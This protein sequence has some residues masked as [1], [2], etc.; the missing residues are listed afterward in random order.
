MTQITD[1]EALS[2]YKGCSFWS[3]FS[4][5]SM[6]WKYLQEAERKLLAYVKSSYR[7]RYVNLGPVVE[8]EDKIWTLE[9]N[10]D[11]RE[12]P[13]VLLH[14]FA[15][16]IGLWCMNIDQISNNCRPVYAMDLLGFGRSSRPQFSK[17]PEQVEV[18]YVNAIEK[19]RSEIKLDK[20]ILLGHS[21]GGY[22]ATA[23]SIQHPE[24]VHHLI[25]ADPWGFP[26]ENKD[27]KNKIPWW[28]KG[29]FYALKSLN[30]LWPVRFAGP[31]GQWLVTNL[32]S[33]VLK[34]YEPVLG[35]QSIVVG[36]YIFQCNSQRA[37][38][39]SAFISLVTGFGWAK[40]PMIKRLE[41]LDKR[42]PITFIYGKNTW[43]DKSVGEI[44]KKERAN[45]FVHI[46]TIPNAGHHVFADQFEEFNKIVDKIC[47]EKVIEIDE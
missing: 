19:W 33:D 28:A 13:I 45:S 4:W 17:D 43:M 24:R 32:R 38:G 30:P 5:S 44:V 41:Y 29:I 40:N 31:Y 25:L 37:T 46:E 1:L 34:K 7:T 27:I 16:G 21:F 47:Q 15:A 18:Q 6:S 8:Q 22:L 23:Y 12:T 42:V 35:E 20:F 10:T 2:I 36:E 26:E 3:W 39:E 11:K 14:G 9:V